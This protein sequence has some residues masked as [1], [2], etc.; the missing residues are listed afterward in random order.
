MS[1]EQHPLITHLQEKGETLT[2]FAKRV[3]M[4]RMQLYRIIAGGSTT[5]TSLRKISAATGGAVPVSE[6]LSSED[7]AA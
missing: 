3:E 6:F 7:T 2:A 5:L 4:S 1:T